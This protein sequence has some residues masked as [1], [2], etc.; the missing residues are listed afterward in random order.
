MW[1]TCNIL[2][3]EFKTPA[4][5]TERWP[6]R[7]CKI[8]KN[9]RAV[10]F[11]SQTHTSKHENYKT[12]RQPT[13]SDKGRKEEDKAWKG[14]IEGQEKRINKDKKK[15]Q[16][17][18]NIAK[19]V[20]SIGGDIWE[21]KQTL[22]CWIQLKSTKVWRNKVMIRGQEEGSKAGKNRES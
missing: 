8:I 7:Q 3:E 5:S 11:N 14:K 22:G 1:I 9:R 2:T 18:E 10:K 17:L 6:S 12:E 16:K 13:G 21:V 20:N 19:R 4:A 15:D